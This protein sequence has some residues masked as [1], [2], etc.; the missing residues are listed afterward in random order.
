MGCCCGKLEERINELFEPNKIIAKE[1]FW[2][3][4]E[5]QRSVGCCQTKG[6]GAL[7]LTS[8][9]LWFNLLC[10]D[11]QIVIPL[12]SILAV[13]VGR[14][15]G[16]RALGLIVDYVDPAS[17]MEDQVI[18]SLNRPQN[19]KM[20]IEAGKGNYFGELE[21]RVS[22]R[23]VECRIIAKEI[24]WANLQFQRSLGSHSQVQGNGA[25]VLTPYML[26]FTLLI[27]EK[28]IEIPLQNITAV[29]VHTQPRRSPMLVIT[30]VDATA[31]NEDQVMFA[32]KDPQ[33]W[34]RMID[35]TIQGGQNRL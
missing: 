24:F 11:T 30:F 20:L 13:R 31:T 34:K 6:S 18:F 7:V 33:Y 32:S 19:W 29:E 14:I 9:V 35:E 4:L 10:P 8:D 1:I 23:F 17:G 21:R 22:Q 26:W 2:A 27:P 28:Q 3:N 15:P 12:R 16:E 25:L 5:Y